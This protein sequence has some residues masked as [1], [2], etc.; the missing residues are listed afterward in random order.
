[1]KG[2]LFGIAAIL[3]LGILAPN[4]PHHDRKLQVGMALAVGILV[5]IAASL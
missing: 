5:A 3:A 2:V 4:V 1:M